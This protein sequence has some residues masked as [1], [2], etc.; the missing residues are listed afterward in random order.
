MCTYALRRLKSL[1]NKLPGR[2]GVALCTADKLHKSL[3]SFR[4]WPV[5]CYGIAPMLVVARC[6]CLHLMYFSHST[7]SAITSSIPPFAVQWNTEFE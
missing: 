6:S 3:P 2:S 7:R 5:A 4:N 1:L